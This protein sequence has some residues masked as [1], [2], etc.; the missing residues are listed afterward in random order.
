MDFLAKLRSSNILT[1]CIHITEI[2]GSVTLQKNVPY[3]SVII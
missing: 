1:A 3:L 2:K